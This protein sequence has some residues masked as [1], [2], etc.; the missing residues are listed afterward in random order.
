MVVA[1][2]RLG[3]CLRMTWAF[4]ARELRFERETA[5]GWSPL[6]PETFSFHPDRHDPF[7]L[8]LQL[9]DL[10]SDSR[11]IEG[12]TR[13]DCQ[14]LV[15]RLLAAAPA[16]VE[17]L[18]DQLEQSGR[19]D[20]AASVRIHAD[21][22]LLAR[23]LA[24]FLREKELETHPETR[25]ARFHLRKLVW[26]CAWVLVRERVGEERLAAWLA[27]PAA[28]ARRFSPAFTERELM[29]AIAGDDDDQAAPLVLALAERAF[30]RWL[31]D[32]CLDTTNDA[33]DSE[34]SPFES[35]EEEVLDVVSV[36]PQRRLRR[37]AHMS[38]F[39]RREGSR[40]CQRLLRALEVWFLRQYDL[41]RSAAVIR[42]EENL[43]RGYGSKPGVLSWH[44]TKAYGVA[45]AAL[46]APC[47]GAAFA[48]ER[49]PMLF[50]VASSVVLAG[51]LGA[52]LWYL[53]VRFLWQKDLAFFHAGV[54]RIGAGII[55]GYLPVFL[56][57]EV[58]DLARRD[59]FPLGV[60]VALMGTT[61]LLYLYVEVKSRIRDSREAFARAR[62]LFLLGILQAEALGL[63]LT[64]LLGRFMVERTWG[65]AAIPVGQ[66]REITP[67]F[68]G[69][70]PR[71][72][73][74]EPFYVYP[75]AILLM[76]FFSLFVGTFLQLLWE[77]LPITEPL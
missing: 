67:T 77:D 16:Y 57:D 37:A 62:R 72:L 70:L 35:R 74:V 12:A 63:I 54:P 38:P 24:R 20:N 5:N 27:A 71:I 7:E 51:V 69:E 66:L 6:F 29:R 17:S 18:L 10:W 42:H 45:I 31:E 2:D 11:R 4:H 61:T 58:W 59:W 60:T 68:V 30:H 49:A 19:L 14:E 55:V 56:I 47:V 15:R 41:P 8:Q 28:G 46:I 65:D 52:V 33:F 73:G 50:D 9:E 32:T 22:V 1:I 44:S 36:E 13:R 39:L 26:R 40:D 43:G 3:L 64:S 23:V 25:F 21:A 48:Y 53:A 34:E 76:T 75:T